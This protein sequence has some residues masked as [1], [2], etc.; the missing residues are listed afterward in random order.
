MQ[1]STPDVEVAGIIDDASL[2]QEIKSLL[3]D[4]KENDIITIRN[5]LNVPFRGKFAR[6]VPHDQALNKQDRRMAELGAPVTKDG[7]SLAHTAQFVTIDAGQSLRLHG[8]AAKVVA[9][10]L[11]TEI[12]QRRNG[13]NKISDPKTRRDIEEEVVMNWKKHESAVLETPDES[14]DRELRELNDPMYQVAKKEEKHEQS[15]PTESLPDDIKPAGE[16]Q[17]ETVS[18][19][20]EDR[21]G[22]RPSEPTAD[23]PKN[24][25]S[26]AKAKAGSSTSRS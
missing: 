14:F 1:N 22:D 11:V 5:T 3:E 21:T 12:I 7:N 26:G 20:G 25:K 16:T 8:Y 19:A 13:R 23:S 4:F 6:S 18:P 9:R 24:P 15:F 17:Q 2:N 10:Q